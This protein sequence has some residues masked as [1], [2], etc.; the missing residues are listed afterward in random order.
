MFYFI[1]VRSIETNVKKC[2]TRNLRGH[3]S[4]DPV[5][6]I[7]PVCDKGNLRITPIFSSS[8]NI[9]QSIRV[10][11]H[12]QNYKNRFIRKTTKNIIKK[13]HEVTEHGDNTSQFF[14]D[15]CKMPKISNTDTKSMTFLPVH[16]YAYEKDN[17]NENVDNVNSTE[18][19][20]EPKVVLVERTFIDEKAVFAYRSNYLSTTERPFLLVSNYCKRKQYLR[21]CARDYLQVSKLFQSTTGQAE[22]EMAKKPQC[23]PPLGPP[24][25][26][27]PPPPRRPP[28]PSCP[29]KKEGKKKKFAALDTRCLL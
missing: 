26:L 27:Q 13:G 14:L 20:E 5:Q 4:Q 19:Y 6:Q 17:L 7:L 2:N 28:L 29:R 25:V 3:V 24:P 23:L 16:F 22:K 8:A 18:V 11:E 15:D 1:P 10:L 12:R 9:D 21:Y